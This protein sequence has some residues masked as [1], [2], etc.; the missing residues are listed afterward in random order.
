M[1]NLV[2]ITA[3]HEENYG[4]FNDVVVDNWKPKGE[5]K[6]TLNIDTEIF[7]YAKEQAIAAIKTLLASQSNN[8][9]RYTYVS[10][11]LVFCEPIELSETDFI[12]QVGIECGKGQ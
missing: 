2:I 5:Q 10:H 9:D 11:E 6:F 4:F 1:K 3:Q 7:M 8:L 12:T